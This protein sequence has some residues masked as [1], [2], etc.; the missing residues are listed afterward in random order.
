VGNQGRQIYKKIST[1][2]AEFKSII[3][4]ELGAKQVVTGGE[5]IL[6]SGVRAMSLAE[7]GNGIIQGFGGYYRNFGECCGIG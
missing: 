7:S 3:Y 1:L 6:M 4:K 2:L 5:A